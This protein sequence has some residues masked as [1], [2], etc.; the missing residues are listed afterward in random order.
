MGTNDTVKNF[1]SLLLK[2][3]EIEK[4]RKSL[5]ESESAIKDSLSSIFVDYI[6]EREMLSDIEWSVNIPF[7]NNVEITSSYYD[8]PGSSFADLV[9]RAGE[10]GSYYHNSI[11]PS[12]SEF[13]A[14][15]F[16]DGTLSISF[17]SICQM[18]EFITNQNIKTINLSILENKISKDNKELE[19]FVSIVDEIR[20]L[21]NN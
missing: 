13:Q 1:D 3:D 16:S 8:G 11:T 21:I 14:L 9:L 19:L 5:C 10:G 7:R 4:T 15:N 12:K 20:K 6:K 2:L 17:S 18:R